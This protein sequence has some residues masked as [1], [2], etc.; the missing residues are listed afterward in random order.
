MPTT[1]CHDTADPPLT[2]RAGR[3]GLSR[4]GFLT[5]AALGA[6]SAVT[7]CSD[8]D[9]RLDSPGQQPDGQS[10]RPSITEEVLPNGRTAGELFYGASM[11]GGTLAPFEQQ[12]GRVL[13][14]HRSFFSSHEVDAL[15]TQAT[16]DVNN[17]RLPMVSSKPPGSWAD[18]TLNIAWME[19][20]IQP[21]S[22]IPGPVYLTVHHEPENDE[23]SY[24]SAADFV[25]MQEAVV[26]QA[27]SATNIVVVPI[28]SSWSFDPRADRTPSSWNVP[29][30][31]VYGLD[32]YN[33]WSPTNGNTWITFADKLTM[34]EGEAAGRPLV[35][36]EYGCRSDPTQPGRAGQWMREAFETALSSGVIAMSYFHSHLNS[37]EGTW[38]LDAE[39]LPVFS[40]LLSSPE[41]AHI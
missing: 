20:L 13:S 35:V 6:A 29:G 27:A 19:S 22:D 38:E 23:E 17:G 34:A 40:E 10:I 39:T 3:S 18:T 21:L 31:A 30:A 11:P 9:K 16:D 24:G 5:M 12:L 7:A 36:G 32:L 28:L 37:P 4:R 26:N 8:D 2:K 25:A 14:C 1:P 41:V 33:S 15:V